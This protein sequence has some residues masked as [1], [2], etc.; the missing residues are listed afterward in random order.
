MRLELP[1]AKKLVTSAK[2]V[3]LIA[4]PILVIA[5]WGVMQDPVLPELK[6]YLSK[7]KKIISKVGPVE[8]LRLSKTTYVQD[9]IDR[10]GNK[11]SGYNLY[12]DY[13]AW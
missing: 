2:Y 9:A 12:S 8:S 3:A 1:A 7:N 4:A 5:W 10:E 6:H 11:T 13:C